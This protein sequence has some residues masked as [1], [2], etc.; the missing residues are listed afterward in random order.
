MYPYR[1]RDHGFD[2][3]LG[4]LDLHHRDR[5]LLRN[6]QH[7]PWQETIPMQLFSLGGRQRAH[8]QHPHRRLSGTSA[9]AH[10]DAGAPSGGWDA[11]RSPGC[12]LRLK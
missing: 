6:T 7:S 12:A 3:Q 8:I 1:P 2:R 9:R 5:R 4:V 11:R 10:A